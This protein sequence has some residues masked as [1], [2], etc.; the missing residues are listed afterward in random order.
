MSQL[1]LRDVTVKS[2]AGEHSNPL[3]IT[4]DCEKT[5]SGVPN[6]CKFEMYNLNDS[7][8]MALREEG[9]EIELSAGYKFAGNKGVIFKGFIRDTVHEVRGVDIVT[10]IEAGD[11]DKMQKEGF[12][13]KTYDPKKPI[14][15]IV[16]DIQKNFMPGVELGEI[17]GLDEAIADERHQ[18]FMSSPVRVLNELSRTHGFYWSVQNGVLETIPADGSL[19]HVTQISPE[20]GLVGVPSITDSGVVFDHLLDPDIRPNRKINLQSKTTDLNGC[21]GEYRVSTVQYVGDNELDSYLV[22]V[23][24]ELLKG[25]KTKAK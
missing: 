13:S 8:R 21:S 19:S 20:S 18:S 24:A 17:K 7:S 15:D 10:M 6:K 14:K 23:E 2:A 9:T 25:G 1:Y 5:A 11:G 22:R 3:R 4:F 16:L 12:V